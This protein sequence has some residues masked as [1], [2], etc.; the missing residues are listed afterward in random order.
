MVSVS[1]VLIVDSVNVRAYAFYPLLASTTHL[2]QHLSSLTIFITAF[3][4]IYTNR[5]V[6]SALALSSSL[7]TILAYIFWDF[8]S[9]QSKLVNIPGTVKSAGLIFF[10]LLGLSPVLKSLTKSTTSDSIWALSVGLFCVE[11]MAHD[12]SSASWKNIKYLPTHSQRLG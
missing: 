8:T 12:Y 1:L 6:P 2:T 7:V 4:G 9:H 3:I 11:I 5:L 10:T